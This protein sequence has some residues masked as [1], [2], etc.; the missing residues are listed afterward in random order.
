MKLWYGHFIGNFKSPTFPDVPSGKEKKNSTTLLPCRGIVA[1]DLIWPEIAVFCLPGLWSPL[2][3]WGKI[4]SFI[5]IDQACSQAT[6]DQ[7]ERCLKLVEVVQLCRQWFWPLARNRLFR[8]SVGSKKKKKNLF[9]SCLGTCRVNDYKTNFSP[10]HTV[11][12]TGPASKKQ[13]YQVRSGQKL[14]CVVTKKFPFLP[15][16]SGQ[17][18]LLKLPIKW[19][20]HKFIN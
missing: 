5:I 13:L 10:M 16:T 19:P 17:A 9:S 20:Y 1:F 8:P 14:Q 18:G 3:A 7:K 2:C 12:S 15:G 11:G 4:F 6:A